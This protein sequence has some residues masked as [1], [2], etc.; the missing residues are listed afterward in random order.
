MVETT[1]RAIV[2]HARNRA[3]VE[4][5]LDP[6]AYDASKLWNCGL[7]LLYEWLDNK[8]LPSGDLDHALKEQLKDNKHYNG[9]HSQSA[10]QVLDLTL[11]TTG[12]T[13]TTNETTHQAT[14]K[15][16][17]TMTRV[18]SSTRNTHVAL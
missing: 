10:Q 18:V 14:A 13:P 5:Q 4:R 3:Q 15:L 7:Y 17:I 2:T 6:H 16:G 11:S 8:N 9:L 12:L 1:N